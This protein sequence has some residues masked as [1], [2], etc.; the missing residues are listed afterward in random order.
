MKPHLVL[1]H[2]APPASDRLAFL[3][4][5]SLNFIRTDYP[6]RRESLKQRYAKLL[7]KKHTKEPALQQQVSLP[8]VDLSPSSGIP[9]PFYSQAST[10]SL[11]VAD[12]GYQQQTLN[13]IYDETASSQQPLQDLDDSQ[14]GFFSLDSTQ[15]S[16]LEFLVPAKLP[17]EPTTPLYSR[18]SSLNTDLDT[19]TTPH[20]T[21][22]TNSFLTD[23]TYPTFPQRHRQHSSSTSL[24]NFYKKGLKIN[25]KRRNS[26]IDTSATSPT[27]IPSVSAS[28]YN[29]IAPSPAVSY[30]M[31]LAQNVGSSSTQQQFIDDDVYEDGDVVGVYTI[32]KE[33]GRGSFSKVYKGYHSDSSG[34]SV[35]A[36]SLPVNTTPSI[37]TTTTAEPLAIKVVSKKKET[38]G[39]VITLLDHETQ[40]WS[41]LIH[42]KIVKMVDVFE[43]ENCVFVVSEYCDCNLL[44]FIERQDGGI[45]SESLAK[46]M[47]KDILQAV[48]YIHGMGVVH[49]DLKLENILV[50]ESTNECKV[51]DFGLSFVVDPNSPYFANLSVSSPSSTIFCAGSI[52]YCAPE[53]LSSAVSH[54]PV[55]KSDIWSVGC[56]FY[57]MVTGVL[58]FWDEFTPRLQY[59]IKKGKYDEEKVKGDGPRRVLRKMLQVDVDKRCTARDI[60]QDE[61]FNT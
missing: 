38:E 4:D 52:P 43:A 5:S 57:A 47:L 42:P 58:P 7:L 11:S 61:W 12:P 51:V 60:L 32:Q 53:E 18:R 54:T 16:A 9:L 22:S 44:E 31:N 30:F 39:D 50:L 26:A 13:I 28:S 14:T 33:I 49:R 2:T 10:D 48:E 8:Q 55:C 59:M 17:S 21:T 40:I 20:Q 45:L 41:T 29:S 1:K 36:N 24:T 25:I 6:D 19:F 34:T 23:K 46:S 27:S 3:N 37:T 15:S 35:P 56:I